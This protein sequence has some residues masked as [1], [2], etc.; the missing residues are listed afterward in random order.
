MFS[1]TPAKPSL[2]PPDSCGRRFQSRTDPSE[3]LQIRSEA[4]TN[5]CK[6]REESD[7]PA[8]D[9]LAE[10]RRYYSDNCAVCHANDGIGKTNTTKGL[11]LKVPDLHAEHVQKLTDGEM[12]YI[13]KNG[14]RLTDIPG[15]DMPDGRVWQLVLLIRQFANENT[16]HR[17]RR[18]DSRKGTLPAGALMQ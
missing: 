16:S 14:V 4:A 2:L 7:P 10:A 15:W 5:S 9:L 11:S 17:S 18:S 13:I 6:G 3:L 8:P 1:F 12:L